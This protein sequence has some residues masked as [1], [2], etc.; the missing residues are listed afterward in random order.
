MWGY[1][2]RYLSR[3]KK[4]ILV[5]SI[6]LCL[7]LKP[8]NILISISGCDLEK[9]IKYHLNNSYPEVFE[10]DYLVAS[11]AVHLELPDSPS[12]FVFKIADF[13]ICK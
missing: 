13:G 6:D 1:S 11:E 7:D 3:V 9:D 8:T 2:H 5:T 12:Q 10:P 4:T